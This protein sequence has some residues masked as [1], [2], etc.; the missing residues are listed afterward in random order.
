MCFV[1]LKSFF[2]DWSNLLAFSIGLIPTILLYIFPPTTQVPFFIFV[3]LL[4]FFLIVLWLC[5]KLYFDIKERE[6]TP[7]IPIIECSHGVCICKTNDFIAYN[8]IVAFYEKD[9]V[10]ER[11]IGYGRV[12]DILS[13]KTAQIETVST[14][15]EIP[16]LLEHINNHKNNIMI[17]PTITLD[18]VNK[19]TENF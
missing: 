13:G 11:L 12:Q 18:T 19:I 6:T 15:I 8:S 9:G 10:Y 16:D 3:L 14:C 1:Q 2:K 5:F 4:F 17:R 7:A